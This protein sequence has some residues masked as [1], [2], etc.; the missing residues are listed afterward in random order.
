MPQERRKIELLIRE[1]YKTQ[2][3][4][5]VFVDGGLH[6]GYHRNFAAMHF[7][8]RIIGIEASPAIF[9]DF[10]KQKTGN[11][12]EQVSG[13]E[14]KADK[15][16]E[17]VAAP[18]NPN[19]FFAGYQQVGGTFNIPNPSKD[20]HIRSWWNVG[21]KLGPEKVTINVSSISRMDAF[22]KL[23]IQMAML[24]LRTQGGFDRTLIATFGEMTAPIWAEAERLRERVSELE[25]HAIF[26]G[27]RHLAGPARHGGTQIM[28]LV[29]LVLTEGQAEAAQLLRELVAQAE[30]DDPAVRHA[31]AVLDF[32]AN[33]EA[34]SARVTTERKAS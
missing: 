28:R 19:Y 5:R 33:N 4:R 6:K 15:T 13:A 1:V 8:D 18:E 17:I 27:E 9:I 24:L 26:V 32:F 23:T 30:K 12:V 3:N 7:S 25:G 10:V 20:L 22:P 29:A 34:R 14:K 2:P 21:A 11:Y 16:L 31:I